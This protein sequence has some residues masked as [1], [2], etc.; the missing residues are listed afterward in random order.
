M[1]NHSSNVDRLYLNL[2]YCDILKINW[3]AKSALTNVLILSKDE[4]KLVFKDISSSL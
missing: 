4:A 1:P 3:F 2:I